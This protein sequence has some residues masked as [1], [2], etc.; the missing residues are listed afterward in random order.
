M[1]RRVGHHVRDKERWHSPHPLVEQEEVGV[2]SLDQSATYAGAQD[3]THIF[4]YA[5]VHYEACLFHSHLRSSHRELAE[6]AHA[7]GLFRVYVPLRIEPLHLA[8]DLNWIRR[9]IELRDSTDAGA[10]LQQPPPRLLDTEAQR[11]ESPHSSDHHP[12]PVH[13]GHAHL[14]LPEPLKRAHTRHRPLRLCGSVRCSSYQVDT[15]TKL[16]PGWHSPG[17]R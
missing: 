12:L 7:L 10:P 9:R 14:L 16:Q 6:A 4:G 15:P 2:L 11:S 1:G 17:L 5:L 3:H 8:H 13:P